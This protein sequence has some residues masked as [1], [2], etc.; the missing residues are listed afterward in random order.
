MKKIFYLFILVTFFACSS[1]D[2]ISE[3][4]IETVENVITDLAATGSVSQQT[5]VEAKKTI[6]GNGTF[7]IV[8]KQA[9]YLNQGHVLLILLSLLMSLISWP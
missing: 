7:Q 8:E 4:V 9:P 2:P 1:D 3:A 5:P 6:Y